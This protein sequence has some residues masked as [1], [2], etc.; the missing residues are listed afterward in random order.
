MDKMAAI[1]YQVIGGI[2]CFVYPISTLLPFVTNAPFRPQSTLH[3]HRL[4]SV[5]IRKIV[6]LIVGLFV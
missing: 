3:F 5:A 4:K 6:M 2:F 1:F